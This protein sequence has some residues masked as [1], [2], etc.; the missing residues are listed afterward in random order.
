MILKVGLDQR[1]DDAP[2]GL[3]LLS[4][5]FLVR[6]CRNARFSLF[7]DVASL[8]LGIEPGALDLRTCLCDA[9][10][11]PARSPASLF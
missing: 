4:N 7:L 3:H 6:R 9:R 5:S 11:F 8:G 2:F 10:S 1:F